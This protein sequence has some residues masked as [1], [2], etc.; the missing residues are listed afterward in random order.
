M[1][2]L[3]EACAS[4]PGG[5]INSTA[6][7][8]LTTVQVTFTVVPIWTTKGTVTESIQRLERAQSMK[9]S[10]VRMLNMVKELK[11]KLTAPT[12]KVNGLKDQST[13]K[14]N[15]PGPMGAVTQEASRRTQSMARELTSERMV[16]CM[17][18]SSVMV[19][20]TDRA[21]SAGRTA[22]FTL[23][24]TCMTK[25]KVKVFTPG[26][27]ALSTTGPGPPVSNTVWG[28]THSRTVKS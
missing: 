9:E 28:S 22:A 27:T 26:Q 8:K 3:M 15:L 14:E 5:K 18:A 19:Q 1:C 23:E 2:S 7:A 6:K 21:R 13:D 12:T 25:R 4:A 16:M 20:C 11:S 17:L 24:T 10:G